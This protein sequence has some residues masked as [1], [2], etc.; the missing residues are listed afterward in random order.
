M[1]MPLSRA[2]SW[3]EPMANSARPKRRV[4]QHAAGE[5]HEER[6]EDQQDRD[7][8]DVVVDEVA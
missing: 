7:R 4:A 1:L 3:L 8:P 5:E 2:A 6:V